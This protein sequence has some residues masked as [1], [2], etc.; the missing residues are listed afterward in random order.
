MV[1]AE[2]ALLWSRIMPE[3]NQMSYTRQDFPGEKCAGTKKISGRE[4]DVFTS[5]CYRFD[6]SDQKSTNL[7]KYKTVCSEAVSPKTI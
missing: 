3:K 7:G 1:K 6:N 5:F 2:G 4:K